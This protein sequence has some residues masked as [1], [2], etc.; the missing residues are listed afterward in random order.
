MAEIN[1]LR[2]IQKVGEEPKSGLYSRHPLQIKRL[3]PNP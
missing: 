2:K 1:V 3:P